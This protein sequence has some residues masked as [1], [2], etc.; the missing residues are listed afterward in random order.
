MELRD[1]LLSV[2]SAKKRTRIETLMKKATDLVGR[3]VFGSEITR[4]MDKLYAE[5]KV[6]RDGKL[7]A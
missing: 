6:D 1:A 4:E 2:L 7:T 3:Q 5:G